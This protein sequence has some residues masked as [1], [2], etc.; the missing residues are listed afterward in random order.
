MIVIGVTGGIAGGKSFVSHQL[1]AMGAA[2]IDADQLGHKVLQDPSIIEQ[3]RS[4]WGEQVVNA[5]GQIDRSRLAK[6]VF[7]DS[8]QGIAATS[9]LGKNGLKLAVL[10]QT[11][12]F[13]KRK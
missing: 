10:Y 1:E 8:Q 11:L 7:A 2:L 9:T 3:I 6:I 12:V 4:R 5:A 13:P